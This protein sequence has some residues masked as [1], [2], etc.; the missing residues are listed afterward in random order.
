MDYRESGPSRPIA[1]IEMEEEEPSLTDGTFNG[2]RYF[3]CNPKKALFVPLN[4]CRKDSRFLDE[5]QSESSKIN[6]KLLVSS[7]CGPPLR[8]K[9]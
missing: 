1:G 8:T 6:C 5:K 9:D 7:C 2:K 3:Q 4:K